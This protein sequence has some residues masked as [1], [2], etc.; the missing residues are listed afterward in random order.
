MEDF[1]LNFKNS[2]VGLEQRPSLV[3]SHCV[4]I[5]PAD[6]TISFRWSVH[7]IFLFERCI[8][9]RVAFNEILRK[10]LKRTQQSSTDQPITPQSLPATK[11]KLEVSIISSPA[12]P[13]SSKRQSPV[14]YTY[15]QA[16]LKT[17]DRSLVGPKDDLIRVR[18][19]HRLRLEDFK[20]HPE[21]SEYAFNEVLRKYKEKRHQA[22]S[23]P[24]L[25]T[26]QTRH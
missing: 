21:H 15:N 1:K 6:F 20:H 9:L 13:A 26:N 12:R 3:R 23:T 5:A 2:N 17:S 25:L 18:P 22:C 19:V 8:S 7:D 11:T 14:T 24:P 4:S 10:P 16:T